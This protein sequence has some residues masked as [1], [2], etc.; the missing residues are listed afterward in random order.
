[1]MKYFKVKTKLKVNIQMKQHLLKKKV[2]SLFV[3]CIKA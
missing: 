3:F 2:S 1:M